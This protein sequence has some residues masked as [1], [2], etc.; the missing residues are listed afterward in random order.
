MKQIE[1]LWKVLATYWRY[2]GKL[3]VRNNKMLE[4]ALIN[5]RYNF[6]DLKK[7]SPLVTFV[8]GGSNIK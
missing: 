3:D 4:N 2:S 1:L 7:D 8:L 5:G 6:L